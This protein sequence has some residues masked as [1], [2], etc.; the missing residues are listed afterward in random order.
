MNSYMVGE[1]DPEFERLLREEEELE[2]SA[3]A[4]Y[5]SMFA[6]A[7][8]DFADIQSVCTLIKNGRIEYSFG[9]AI[10]EGIAKGKV[11]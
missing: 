3:A 2:R 6:S 5:Q 7:I 8:E 9:I 4:D 10:I 11:G 1:P